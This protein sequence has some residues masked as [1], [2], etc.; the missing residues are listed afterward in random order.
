MP[1]DPSF[2]NKER[3][4]CP[5]PSPLINPLSSSQPFHPQQQALR[6]RGSR[7]CFFNSLVFPPYPLWSNLQLGWHKYPMDHRPKKPGNA[8]KKKK[9]NPTSC[10]FLCIPRR[11]FCQPLL[12]FPAGAPERGRLE[13]LFENSCTC[14]PS[15][16][17]EGNGRL[18]KQKAYHVRWLESHASA[19]VR[20]S[21][22]ICASCYIG[23]P[24]TSTRMTA[25]PESS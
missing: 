9:R 12:P 25:V 4:P 3:K 24:S 14:G 6:A 1:T 7:C 20:T 16:K 21:S 18:K 11:R 8:K 17:R 22:V 13:K 23:P 10:C 19:Q 2:Q 15:R 5:P